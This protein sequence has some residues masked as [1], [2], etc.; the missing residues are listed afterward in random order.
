MIDLREPRLMWLLLLV[1]VLVIALALDGQ[2]R[3]R[4]L[5]RIGHL[6]QIQRM[7][8]GVSSARRRWKGV[9]L[10]LAVACLVV[11]I[12]APETAGTA[13]LEPRR[14]LDIVVALDFSRSMLAPDVYP[15][16]LERAKRE[17]DKLIDGLKGD[18]V[19]LVAFAGVSLSYP[20][21]S[22]YPAAKLFW[23]DLGPDDIPVGGTNLAGAL[24]DGLELL[25]HGKARRQ[26][27]AR[28][29]AQVIILLTDGADTE[30]GALEVAR[31]AAKRGVKIHAVGIGTAAG[32]FVQLK[33][34]EGAR[35]FVEENGEPVRMLL[36]A[37]GLSEIAAATGGDFFQVDP[38]RFG[39]E[40]VQR[41]IAALERTEEEARVVHDR[42]PASWMFL[43]P[44]LLFLIAE[45]VIGDRRR[46]SRP[47]A[48]VQSAVDPGR[49]IAP[50]SSSLLVLVLLAL[51]PALAGFELLERPNPDVE[52][53]NRLLAAGKAAEALT[54]YDRALDARPDDPAIHYDRG[55]ALYALGRLPEAQREFQRASEESTDPSLR[56][57]AIY[58]MGNALL[59]Q[60]RP[61]EA[62]AAYKRTL[63]LRPDDRRAKWN[64]ELALR[65]MREEQQKKDQQSKSS[66]DKSD[67][68]KGDPQKSDQPPSDP[69]KDSPDPQQQK[70]EE[71]AA[72]EQAAKEQAAKEQAAKEQAA[73]E[74]AA[75][76]QAAKE[77]PPE[78]G[79]PEGAQGKPEDGKPDPV[80]DPKAA[81]Q[82]AAGRA[83]RDIDRQ[84]AEAV[85]EAFERVE[86][87]VQK[88]LA[89]RKA[90]N[91]RPR[92]DW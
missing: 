24:R 89:R 42:A 92:K 40:R 27:A 38:E 2:I 30:G 16:R 75:K 84:D 6:P 7:T 90:G 47:K 31:E 13:H 71:Q 87:T 35:E 26:A 46:G 86:P 50:I 54:A 61:K 10:V 64:L 76:E 33:N 91:R 15:S 69:K 3:R 4:V 67:P 63:G 17:L 28:Q 53:G 5:E 21:T 74:Q 19:G 80:R 37:K 43:L 48:P 12:A 66:D 82:V 85:L 60:E 9:L 56:A 18:R 44:A 36:D 70:Q 68:K 23:R 78:K 11:A 57:D 58:N 39:V 83:P 45:G 51:A 55:A 34:A 1:P 41:A 88:D 20:L 73:K 22:D 52:E 79:Q 8:A 72:K 62:L 59:K 49:G 32:E 65:K 29:P 77:G 25:Q 81:A 14:G